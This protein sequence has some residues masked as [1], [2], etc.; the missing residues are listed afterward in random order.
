MASQ[1]VFRLPQRNSIQDLQL[2]TEPITSPSSYEV[3]IRIRSV[4]L[5]F[6][7][8][9]VATGKYPFPVKDN[10]VPCS[11]LAGSAA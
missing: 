9:A 7:D 10:V 8:F 11:D 6:R 3:L 4:A 5:N 2:G 1:Q